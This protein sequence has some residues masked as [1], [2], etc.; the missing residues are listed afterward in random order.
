MEGWRVGGVSVGFDV[1]LRRLVGMS[2][3]FRWMFHI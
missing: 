1:I 3:G 2:R